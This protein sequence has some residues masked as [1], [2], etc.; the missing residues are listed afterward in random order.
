MMIFFN[1]KRIL[2]H[3]LAIYCTEITLNLGYHLAISK[4][5]YDNDGE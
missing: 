2:P 4:S 1:S 3:I 5:M